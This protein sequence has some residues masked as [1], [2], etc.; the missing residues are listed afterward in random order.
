MMMKTQQLQ[1]FVSIGCVS[2]VV[3]FFYIK[4]RKK[5]DFPLLYLVGSCYNKTY[6]CYFY[7]N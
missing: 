5:K 4:E 2:A 3:E 6:M 7:K 1:V